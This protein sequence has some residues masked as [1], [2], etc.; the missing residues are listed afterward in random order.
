[1]D[2][3]TPGTEPG[4]PTL[5][6]GIYELLMLGLCVYVLLALT[7]T[8]FFRLDADNAASRCC[9]AMSESFEIS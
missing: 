2:E 9:A 6:V 5:K 3:R 1:M 7:T 4:K 8:T